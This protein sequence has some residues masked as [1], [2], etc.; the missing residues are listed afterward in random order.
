MSA[1]ADGTFFVFADFFDCAATFY[2]TMSALIKLI[3]IL[4]FM[5]S[6]TAVGYRVI[7]M[8]LKKADVASSTFG[9]LV[10]CGVNSSAALRLRDS[11]SAVCI[12]SLIPF[13]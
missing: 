1:I 5:C 7:P 6:L 3:I 13:L 12:V 4:L 11:N 2:G 10:A 8:L 9:S